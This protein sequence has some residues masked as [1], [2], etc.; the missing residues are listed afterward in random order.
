MSGI[1]R[2]A[3]SLVENPCLKYVRITDDVL[4]LVTF[5]VGADSVISHF[6]AFNNKFG[7][8]NRRGHF[9]IRNRPNQ[10]KFAHSF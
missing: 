10:F 9:P 3:D 4:A 1:F 2:L 7:V 6:A 5:G 8:D